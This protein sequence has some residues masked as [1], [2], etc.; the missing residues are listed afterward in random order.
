M[1][2]WR[3]PKPSRPGG[4]IGTAAVAPPSKCRPPRAASIRATM[5]VPRVRQREDLGDESKDFGAVI[6]LTVFVFVSPASAVLVTW[7]FQG[8]LSLVRGPTDVLSPTLNIGDQFSG[9]S[10]LGIA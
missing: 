7:E 1:T 9:V 6:A 10:D 5:W 8:V 4:K 3:N 2:D